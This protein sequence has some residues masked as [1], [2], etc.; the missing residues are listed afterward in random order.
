MPC[1]F[2]GPRPL[3]KIVEE[4]IRAALS[5][6]GSRGQVVVS[7]ARIN[8]LDSDC[9]TL[10]LGNIHC[11]GLKFGGVKWFHPVGPFYVYR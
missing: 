1:L 11:Y 7:G 3:Q 9:E 6:R 2:A 10:Y 8:L 5:P 4:R